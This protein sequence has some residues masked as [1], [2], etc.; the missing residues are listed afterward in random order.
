MS[1]FS[2]MGSVIKTEIENP[3]IKNTTHV[4]TFAKYQSK[5]TALSD[6]ESVVW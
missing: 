6:I 4:T 3:T 2:Q 5:K 1:I